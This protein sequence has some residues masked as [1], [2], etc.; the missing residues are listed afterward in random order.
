MLSAFPSFKNKKEKSEVFISEAGAILCT[1]AE[2][3]DWPAR[4]KQ[5]SDSAGGYVIAKCCHYINSATVLVE[6]VALAI[7]KSF[8]TK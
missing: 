5:E 7:E 3:D 1:A 6:S 2:S 8:I 4:G